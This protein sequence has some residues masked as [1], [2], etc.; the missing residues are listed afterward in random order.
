M[1]I[2]TSK[3]KRIRSRYIV[4]DKLFSDVFYTLYDGFDAQESN[5]VYVLKFH[6]P[7]VSPQ[8]ADFCI[9]A[10]QSYLYQTLPNVFQLIDMEYDGED[11]FLLYKNENV[12]L[13][14]LDLYLNKIQADPDSA[15]K[16]Y[17]LLLKISRI[18]FNLEEKR[19]TFGNFSLNNIFVTDDHRVIL[20]PSK[21]NLICLE[22]FYSKLDI[23]DASI[24]IPPEFLKSF[25]ASIFTDVY[26]FGVL[27]FYIVTS[28]WPL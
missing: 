12:S 15:E 8:F 25:Q 1:D 10:L 16:R 23:F 27:A 22:Y 9:Q 18:I 28:K 6:S 21:I 26:S 24:F 11:L 7:L 20:G 19:L 17:K 14:S 2:K 4:K 5:A 3:E 13:I